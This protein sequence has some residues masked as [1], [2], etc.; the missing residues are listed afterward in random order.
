[1]AGIRPAPFAQEVISGL[2]ENPVIRQEYE[3]LVAESN[4]REIK[5][6]PASLLLPFFDDF[7]QSWI[8]PLSNQ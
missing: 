8:Y 4:T 2:Y 7:S 1:M 6:E 3:K 5:E